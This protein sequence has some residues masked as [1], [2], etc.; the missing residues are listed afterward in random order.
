MD[1]TA[2]GRWHTRA[3]RLSIPH[4]LS[5]V[6][7]TARVASMLASEAMHAQLKSQ[8]MERQKYT[9]AASHEPATTA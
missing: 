4:M 1:L 3:M 7:D 6:L 2:K 9:T 5:L 8:E